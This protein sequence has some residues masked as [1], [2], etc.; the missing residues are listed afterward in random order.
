MVLFKKKTKPG[1]HEVVKEG[2]EDIININYEQYPKIPSIE[3]DPL[4][5]ASVIEKLAQSPKVTRVI[6]H[7]K[8]R[9]EYSYNQTSMLLEVAQIY[10]HFIKQKQILTQAALEVFGPIQDLSL[11][12]RNLQR[13]ILDLLRTDPIGAFVETKRLLREERINLARNTSEEAKLSSQPYLNVL[14]EIYTL[15]NKTKLIDGTREFLDGYE[16]GNRDAY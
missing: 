11:R 12:V 9:Y 3:D 15:L 6:F 8:K 16:I 14:T 1:E 4:V 2:Q 10:N 13:I 5:M 7:Q